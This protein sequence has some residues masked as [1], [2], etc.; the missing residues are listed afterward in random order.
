MRLCIG[1]VV[2]AVGCGNKDRVIPMWVDGILLEGDCDE[3]YQSYDA[4]PVIATIEIPDPDMAD[5]PLSSDPNFRME[6]LPS[7]VGAVV[8]DQATYEEIVFQSMNFAE[9]PAVDFTTQQALFVWTQTTTCNLQLE[10]WGVNA[11]TDGTFVLDVQFYDESLNCSSTCGVGHKGLVM[12]SVTNTE[13]ATFCK[14]TRPGCEP[15]AV[16]A[17]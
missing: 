15:P 17:R 9:V 12:A 2:A 13:P 7:T 1:V 4:T 16:T 8:T 3:S 11:R 6:N 10:E 5:D 14:R